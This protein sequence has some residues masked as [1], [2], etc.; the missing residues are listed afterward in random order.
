MPR[1]CGQPMCGRIKLHRVVRIEGALK[2]QAQHF[3]ENMSHLEF[4]RALVNDDIIVRKTKRQ[5]NSD[6]VPIFTISN[7]K[8][9]HFREFSD[10]AS[11]VETWRGLAARRTWYPLLYER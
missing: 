1:S 4:E 5:F 6:W 3:Q 11:A 9:T 7:G 8:V 2:L 10:T